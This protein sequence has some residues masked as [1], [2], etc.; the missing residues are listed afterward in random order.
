MSTR[1]EVVGILAGYVKAGVPLQGAHL[2]GSSLQKLIEQIGV[3]TDLVAIV[4]VN[5]VKR[6]KTY[7]LQV[8]DVVKLIPFV[9]G[10]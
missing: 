5:G 4:M 10:G 2:V 3:P 7:V 9:G 6:D 1:V 8:D